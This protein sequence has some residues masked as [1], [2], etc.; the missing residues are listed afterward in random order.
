MANSFL[1]TGWS[2]PPSFD[3]S[4]RQVL[5]F[6]D[7]TDVHSSLEILLSTRL[8]ERV[9]QPDYGCNLNEMLFEPMTTTFKTY[10]K[11]LIKN[12]VLNY[13]TRIDLLS[14]DIDDSGETEGVYF[15]KLSYAIRTTNS[16]YNFVFPFYTNEGT[17][18]IR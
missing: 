15:L 16:R 6:K 4:A 7:E 9:L 18:I 5:M 12:A 13:E 11:D 8:R 2:F 10:I 17:Q 1:G 14:I 3:K